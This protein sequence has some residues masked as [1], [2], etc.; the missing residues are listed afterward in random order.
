M[1]ISLTIL[2]TA[3]G[4]TA[5]LAASAENEGVFQSWAINHERD[6]S[7]NEEKD[8]RMAVWL[9]NHEYIE[10]HNNQEPKPSYT[11][12]HNQFSDMTVDEYHQHNF[13]GKY[14]PGVIS[15]GE[16]MTIEQAVKENKLTSISRR[17]DLLDGGDLP[18]SV[19]WVRDGAVT[20]VK[21]QGQCGSC[22]AFSTIGALEGARFTETG[23]LMSLSEQELVDCDTVKNHGCHGGLMDNAFLF[24]EN[25][26][27]IC[28]LEDYPYVGYK[29]F[30]Y[31]CASYM[32]ECKPQPNTKV[33]AFE[34]IGKSDNALKEALVKQPVSIAINAKD[35]DFQLYAGGVF[36]KSCTPKVDHG[37]L[38]VGY[39]T[40]DGEEYWLVK[41]SW[42]DKW[43]LN[44]YIY[45]SVKSFNTPSE[46]QCGIHTFASTPQVKKE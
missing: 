42:G 12:K 18:A 4:F 38:A 3:F 8:E 27:G 11:L 19:D 33:I 39:G 1:L 2:T 41:N 7:S 26:K 36:S 6:Y 15:K 35:R 22:W 21:N 9:D 31:S 20:E 13:L 29:H 43:G 34:D 40:L 45:M 17:R 32:K 23:V 37:V 28:S 25:Q 16:S 10:Q 44:G 30:F 46:G 24:D 14:F 5:A